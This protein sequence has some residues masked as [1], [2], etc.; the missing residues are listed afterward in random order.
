MAVLFGE[1]VIVAIDDVIKALPS[2]EGPGAKARR[3]K[4]RIEAGCFADQ[5]AEI[6]LQARRLA[7]GAD[8]RALVVLHA[9]RSREMDAVDK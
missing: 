6:V 5:R 3:C 9:E 4:Y 7:K 1:Q 2:K 8:C